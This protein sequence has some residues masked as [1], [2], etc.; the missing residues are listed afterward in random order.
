MGSELATGIVTVFISDL[1]K[2]VNREFRK[3]DGDT[4]LF[5]VARASINQ[6]NLHRK[7]MSLSDWAIK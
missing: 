5:K 4:G 1:G 2:W 7:L 6:I 3:F